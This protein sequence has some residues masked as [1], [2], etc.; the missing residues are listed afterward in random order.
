MALSRVMLRS[1]KAATVSGVSEYFVRSQYL[2][3]HRHA[4]MNDDQAS[5]ILDN[6]RHGAP[7][8]HLPSALCSAK[9]RK[10]RY[11]AEPY[12]E[13]QGMRSTPRR[14]GKPVRNC[15]VVVQ[16]K[17]SPTIWLF[18]LRC[19]YGFGIVIGM[20]GHRWPRVL[21]APGC[22]KGEQGSSCRVVCRWRRRV[23]IA[24]Y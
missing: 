16:G 22:R 19:G 7:E 1:A 21:S 13:E 20:S 8:P 23:L 12:P 6:V 10:K 3:I 4:V 5:M 18:L 9:H 24:R 14:L 15:S 17:E 11:V 2:P